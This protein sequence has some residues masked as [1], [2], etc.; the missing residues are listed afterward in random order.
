MLKKFDRFKDKYVYLTKVEKLREVSYVAVGKIQRGE[1]SIFTWD[2]G[3][4]AVEVI[5]SF[6]DFV[7]TSPVVMVLD[8]TEKSIRFQTHGGVYLMEVEDET[9]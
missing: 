3:E 9:V 5:G 8:E 6:K 1:M 7:R 4:F 2:D